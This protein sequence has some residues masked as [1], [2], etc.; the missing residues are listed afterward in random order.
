LRAEYSDGRL[1]TSLPSIPH[2]GSS[3]LGFDLFGFVNNNLM[4][5][6]RWATTEGV[7]AAVRRCSELL[8]RSSTAK[9]FSFF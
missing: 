7:Q 2:S 8:K 9:G 3:P 1:G 4:R 6:K 5:G